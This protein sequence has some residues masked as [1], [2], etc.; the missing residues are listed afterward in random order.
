MTVL[1][2]MLEWFDSYVKRAE[3]RSITDGEAGV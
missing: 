1:A 2:E 3:P